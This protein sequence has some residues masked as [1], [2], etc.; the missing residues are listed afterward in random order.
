VNSVRQPVVC[1][2]HTASLS[3]SSP[4]MLLFQHL[5]DFVKSTS[6]LM[7]LVD[8]VASLLRLVM[9]R[10]PGIKE[11]LMAAVVQL[12]FLAFAKA[13]ELEICLTHLRHLKSKG[14]SLERH[15]RYQRELLLTRAFVI[16]Y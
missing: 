15:P 11:V 1:T 9:M 5:F 2:L 7:D 8:G 16:V 3:S 13:I 12:H 10:A 6:A 14:L 4:S